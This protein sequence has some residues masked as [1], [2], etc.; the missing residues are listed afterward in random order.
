[1]VGKYDMKWKG[2]DVSVQLN[3]TQKLPTC[4]REGRFLWPPDDG[5]PHD[6][7]QSQII[8]EMWI[9]TQEKVNAAEEQIK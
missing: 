6:D 1:M 8:L 4:F 7:S 2:R 5:V 3:T 9:Y